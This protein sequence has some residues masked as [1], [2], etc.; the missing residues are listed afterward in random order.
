MPDHI[1]IKKAGKFE[2]VPSDADIARSKTK[3]DKD[4]IKAKLT[5]EEL[6]SILHNILTRLEALEKR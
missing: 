4:K 5:D 6:R 3:E 1:V 2:I